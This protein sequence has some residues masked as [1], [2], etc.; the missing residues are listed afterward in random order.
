MARKEGH[1]P[2]SSKLF[3]WSHLKDMA[4][5]SMI[6]HSQVPNSLPCPWNVHSTYC[7]HSGSCSKKGHSL[8]R[9]QWYWD[10]QQD[11]GDWIQLRSLHKLIFW[12]AGAKT[13]LSCSCPKWASQ[14]PLL[15]RTATNQTG[16]VSFF[17]LPLF[18][19]YRGLFAKHYCKME[20]MR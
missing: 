13:Y 10:H 1:T 2:C 14:V 17:S 5:E 20:L 19:V 7:P 18:S 6:G 8:G 11:T 16:A 12:Q 9:V 15:I 3:F 4:I